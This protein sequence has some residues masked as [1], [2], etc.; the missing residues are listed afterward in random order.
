MFIEGLYIYC[1]ENIQEI[2]EYRNGFLFF[3]YDDNRMSLFFELIFVVFLE[4]LF[5]RIS[6]RVES[7]VWRVNVFI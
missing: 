7:R 4:R 2:L 5:V 6:E 3:L 1:I